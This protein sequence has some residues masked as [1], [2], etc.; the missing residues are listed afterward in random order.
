MLNLPYRTLQRIVALL[1]LLYI[2]V[3]AGLSCALIWVFHS[4]NYVLLYVL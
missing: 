4:T 3:M 1:G 2:P